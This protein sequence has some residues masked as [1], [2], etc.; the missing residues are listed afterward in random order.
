MDDAKISARDEGK[1]YAFEEFPAYCTGP[2]GQ[3]GI[4]NSEAEVPAG[5]KM[6]N[7]KVKGGKAK[8]AEASTPPAVA[9]T[10]TPAVVQSGEA[11]SG[12]VE[13]DADGWP[14]TEEL[15]AATKTKTGAGLWRM[16]V[17]V[18]RP[19]PKTAPLDL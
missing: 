15:H 14:W 9:A 3:D 8:P 17:G 1:T 12:S 11:P 7:G 13:L 6:P 2:N 18:S 19:A 16:K 10:E 4:F 5:W